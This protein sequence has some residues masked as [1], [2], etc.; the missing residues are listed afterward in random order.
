MSEARPTA[1][2]RANAESARK[3]HEMEQAIAD[4]RLIVRQM[5]PAEHKEADRLRTIRAD[6]RDKRKALRATRG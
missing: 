5:T 3:R 1:R 6:E 4:G 2:E